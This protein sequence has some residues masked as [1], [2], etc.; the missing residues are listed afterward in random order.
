MKQQEP[1]TNSGMLCAPQGFNWIFKGA[2]P[3]PTT[4]LLKQGA[5]EKAVKNKARK[6]SQGTLR[7]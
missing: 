4:P 6:P 1:M 5:L 7:H 3:T 2:S